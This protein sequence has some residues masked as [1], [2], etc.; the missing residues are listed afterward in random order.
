VGLRV[1]A[2]DACGS[3]SPNRKRSGSLGRWGGSSVRSVVRVLGSSTGWILSSRPLVIAHRGDSDVRDAIDRRRPVLIK[4]V[5]STSR[6]TSYYGRT[7]TCGSSTLARAARRGTRAGALADKAVP[8]EDPRARPA[9]TENR[10]Y[11]IT[12][13]IVVHACPRWGQ[14]LRNRWRRQG[15]RCAASGSEQRA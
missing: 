6:S 7:V 11:V 14:A 15:R 5:L 12:H 3:M 2:T 9:M 13:M 4:L 1:A 10:P 8:R